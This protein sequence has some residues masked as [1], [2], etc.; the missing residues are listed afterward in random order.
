MT[1]ARGKSVDSFSVN[2]KDLPKYDEF[3]WA[4]KVANAFKS[5][6]HET[7]V[8]AQDLM[9]FLPILAANADD[10]NGDPVCFPLYYISKLIRD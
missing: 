2:V 5:N 3:I 9:S 10:P 1:E 6:H 7:T 8:G 4:R